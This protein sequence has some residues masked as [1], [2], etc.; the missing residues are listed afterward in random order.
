MSLK[1]Q[2][3][4][5]DWGVEQSSSESLPLVSELVESVSVASQS[6]KSELEMSKPSTLGDSSVSSEV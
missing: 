5:M 4:F 6:L 2:G 3:H 1:D